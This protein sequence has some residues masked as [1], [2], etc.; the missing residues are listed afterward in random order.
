MASSFLHNIVS[1]QRGLAERILVIDFNVELH[2]KIKKLGVQVDYGDLS[3]SDTLI[4]AG[5]EKA[6]IVIYYSSPCRCK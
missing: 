3:N 5:I 6:K 2:A 1:N 4:E